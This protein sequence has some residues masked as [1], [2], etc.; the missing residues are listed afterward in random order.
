MSVGRSI[1]RVVRP[2]AS[3]SPEFALAYVRERPGNGVPVLVIPG[4]PGLGSVLPYRALRRWAAGRDIDLI[5]V[6]HR[7]VGRSRHDLRGRS[8]PPSAM[9]IEAVVDDFAAV[10]DQERIDRV[11]VYGSSYG[12]YLAS[13]F[14]ARHPERVAGMVLDSALQS[15]ADID[16][17]RRRIRELWW[18]AETALA[19]GVRE[20]VAR[21]EPQRMLLD[22]LR[23]GHELI[24]PDFVDWLVRRRL[25]RSGGR[26][27]R[28]LAAYAARD[29]SI[30]R[31]PRVYEFDLAGVI[32]FRELH[33]GAPVDGGPLDPAETYAGLAHRFP[34]FVA[35]PFD[36]SAEVA[37]FE[38]PVVLLA[39][40]RD[41]R[42]P[43]DIA[44]RVARIVPRP[45]LVEIANGHS[46]LETHPAAALNAIR[47]LLRGEQDR[48]P[49]LAATIDALPRRGIAARVPQLVCGLAR[50][51][52]FPGIGVVHSA[53][54]V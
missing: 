10:L 36:L 24:G 42:T 34:A 12:S 21:G 46:A 43:I 28:A 25:A 17:E 19:A 47:L 1:R 50:T 37:R 8:L 32:A 27:W 45:T 33:Y 11:H 23:A 49:V 9:R 2:G 38:W 18:D 35:E 13:G 15:T 14:G 39:G 30:V 4:G 54:S 53:R 40:N 52:G 20:L 26:A 51:E 29:E 41:L 7:G 6:E 48:L 31:V 16:V 44:R 22:V 3:G 5:M